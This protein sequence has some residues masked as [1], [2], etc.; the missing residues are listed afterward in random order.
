M[1]VACLEFI[2]GTLTLKEFQSALRETTMEDERHLLEVERK[3]QGSPR[4]DADA[5]R[6][7]L[8]GGGAPGNAPRK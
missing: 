6:K 3:L 2:K 8:D 1:C 5:A 7:L 4:G